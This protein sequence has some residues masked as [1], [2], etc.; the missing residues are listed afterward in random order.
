MKI[1]CDTSMKQQCGASITLDGGDPRLST[2]CMRERGHAGKHNIINVDP[3][4]SKTAQANELMDNMTEGTLKDAMTNLIRPDKAEIL[5]KKYGPF[6]SD[7][8]RSHRGY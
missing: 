1:I 5:L 3:E 6:S 2:Y 8:P 7:D 4:V